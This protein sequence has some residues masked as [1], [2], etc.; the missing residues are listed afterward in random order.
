MIRE[1][2]PEPDVVLQLKP[3]EL[4]IPLLRCI[5]HKEAAGHDNDLV[6][7]NFFGL[8]LVEEFGG[9]QKIEVAKAI[10]EAWLWLEREIMIAPRPEPGAGRI[11][12]VTERG[13][14][15]AEQ[16]DIHNYIRSSLIPRGVLDPRL[17]S[18]IQHLFIRGDYDTAV[19]QAFKEV[20][21]RVRER[22]SLPQNLLGVEL[23][24][25]AF[26]DELGALTNHAQDIAERQS[27][28]HLFAGAIGLFKNPSS[29]RDVNWEDPMECAELIYLAN[30][31]LRIVEKHASVNRS[32][33]ATTQ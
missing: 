20:E 16:S 19:F 29:H 21:I 17:V 6:R 23:M 8:V 27:T 33:A 9:D 31:L 7:E 12:Y 15:L 3:E 11:V 5:I 4:A 10:T 18:K 2:M 22:A 14:R 32:D 28:S 25:T 24:R 30:H 26:H 13:K 1:F